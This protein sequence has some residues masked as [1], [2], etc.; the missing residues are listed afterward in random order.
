MTTHGIAKEANTLAKDKT[1]ARMVTP[2][3]VAQVLA[4]GVVASLAASAVMLLLRLVAGI[5]T[6]PELV[7]ERILPNLDAGTFV[8]LLIRYGKINPLLAALAGQIAAGILIAPLYLLITG[9]VVRR[10]HIQSG[11]RARWAAREEWLAA[12]ILAGA[13]WLIALALFWPVLAENLLG[14][15]VLAARFITIAGMAMI[16]GCYGAVLVVVDHSL[17]R[18]LSGRDVVGAPADPTRRALL[19]RAGITSLAGLLLGGAAVDLLVRALGLRSN[20]GYEGMET[21]PP[22]AALT[23]SS[24]FYV[25]SKNVL[26]PQVSSA[27][28]RLDVGGLV[29]NPGSYD[30]ASLQKLACEKRDITLECIANGVSGHLLSTA[31]WHGVTLETLL[32]ARGGAL[33]SATQVLF[34]S[35]DGYQSSLPLA[36]LLDVRT[37]LAWQMNGAPLPYRHGYPLRVIVPGRFGEQSPKWLTRVDLLDHPAKGFYQRQGWYDGPVY[38]ISRI[39]NPGR[40]AG[41][42]LG[43]PVQVHGVAYAGTRGIA[44]VEVSTDSGAT[45]QRATL[46]PAL[47]R[48]TWVLW[49][50]SWVPAASGPSTLVV[51]ASDGTGAPQITREQGTVPNGGTGLHRVAVTVG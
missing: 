49:S 13:L 45:W 30:Q 11:G 42:G 29:R 9:L 23:P 27:V 50:F 7:G 18:P 14:F 34:T 16:F 36:D 25:V 12:G 10:M 48:E 24:E 20:L 47:S 38:T 2:I 6:L 35:A 22:I 46:Q 44:S 19:A 28:W 32:E 3:R 37:L 41:L 17:T 21:V 1:R 15:P 31:T 40:G 39:D 5:V 26:D 33:P 8:G 51:R 4:A 43:K